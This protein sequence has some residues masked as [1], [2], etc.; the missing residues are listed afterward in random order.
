MLGSCW[1]LYKSLLLCQ[2]NIDVK[3]ESFM[4]KIDQASNKHFKP[5]APKLILDS[6]PWC[7]VSARFSKVTPP[8]SNYIGCEV[9]SSK[10]QSNDS[11]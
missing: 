6:Q 10:R 11:S 5:A 2:F 8:L 4:R 1:W 3:E 9:Y 7:W